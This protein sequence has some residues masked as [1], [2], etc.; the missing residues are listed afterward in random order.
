MPYESEANS[1]K[2]TFTGDAMI[3]RALSPFREERFLALRASER[4]AAE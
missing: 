2:L 3:S 1:I 4:A